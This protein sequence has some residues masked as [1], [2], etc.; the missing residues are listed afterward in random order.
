MYIKI[1][2]KEYNMVNKKSKSKQPKKAL[3]VA[4]KKD[5]PESK[6]SSASKKSTESKKPNLASSKSKVPKRQNSSKK[7]LSVQPA[8]EKKTVT[9][10]N[11]SQTA[12][13]VNPSPSPAKNPQPSSSANPASSPPKNSHLLY[14]PS[15]LNDYKQYLIDL[16]DK[17]LPDL[18]DMCRKN[19][20]KVTGTKKE[21]ID[22]I[23]DA[24][25]LGVIPKCPACGGGR[26]K[27]DLKTKTYHC[28]GYLEDVKFIN[29][30]KSFTYDDIKRVP[31]QD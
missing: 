15:Q 11:D 6:K 30:H 9:K 21:L 29:C 26:P 28:S 17:K 7:G 3:K 25:I 20:M 18:K 31:W 19:L 2:L 22:R 10:K 23:S 16:D 12:S 5:K 14:T 13:T 8:K 1:I 27:L 4:H 24:K